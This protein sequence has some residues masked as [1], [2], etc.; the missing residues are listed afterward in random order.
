MNWIWIAIRVAGLTG[1]FLLTL[2]LL[3]GI[4]SHVPR[5]KSFVLIFHQIIGQVGLLFIGIHA[6]LL[7]FDHYE[8]FSIRSILIPFSAPNEPLLNGLGT[9]ATYLLIIV[10]VTSDFMKQIG[11]SLWKKTHYLVFPL[12]FLSSIHGL[13]LGSDSQTIW[14]EV[15]YA[16]TTITV[17]LS[18]LFLVFKKSKP[19]QGRVRS[20]S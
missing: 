7:I 9:I 16:S 1:Y 6:Y 20:V 11:R 15:L 17:I 13:F 18:T 8:P 4:Y 19:E 2:T 10:V 3:V 14:G 12:W 5:K